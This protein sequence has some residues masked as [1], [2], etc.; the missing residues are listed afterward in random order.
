MRPSGTSVVSLQVRTLVSLRPERGLNEKMGSCQKTGAR[1]GHNLRAPRQTFLFHRERDSHTW[2][3]VRKFGFRSSM[4]LTEV[5][6]PAQV[7]RKQPRLGSHGQ[8]LIAK[9][10]PWNSWLSRSGVSLRICLSDDLSD[11]T[12]HSDA[13]FPFVLLPSA[14][15]GNWTQ[16]ETFLWH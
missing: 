8:V 3:M 9:L 12:D 10:Q 6:R 1:K 16:A 4:L 11:G 15:M 5:L 13:V 14:N 2:L 7:I